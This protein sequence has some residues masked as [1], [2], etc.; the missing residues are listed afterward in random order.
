MQADHGS[1]QRRSSQEKPLKLPGCLFQKIDSDNFLYGKA[2]AHPHRAPLLFCI[3]LK[4][5]GSRA[6]PPEDCGGN[7]GYEDLVDAMKTPG[8]PDREDLIDWLGEEF[9][10]EAFDLKE[11][12]KRLSKLKL[13]KPK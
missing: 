8:H 9:D 13:D 3:L 1:S 12:N 11:A 6:C 10:P 5:L 7:P 4:R 2:A